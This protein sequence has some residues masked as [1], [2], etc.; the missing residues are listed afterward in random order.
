MRIDILVL[1]SW[2]ENPEVSVGMI[3]PRMVFVLNLDAA[4]LLVL[5]VLK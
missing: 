5:P 4:K 3:K 1:M 2:A